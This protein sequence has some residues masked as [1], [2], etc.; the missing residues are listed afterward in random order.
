MSK[1][2][3]NSVE[4]QEVTGQ[5]GAEILRLWAAMVDYSEDQRIGPTILKT[6][7]DS[8]RKLRNTV[9][10]LLGALAGFD[11]A[12]RV[13]AEEAPPLERFILHRLLELDGQA[14]AAYQ[15]HAFTAVIRPLSDF[16]SNDLSSLFFDIRRDVLYCDRP[17]SPRRRACR[18]VMDLVFERLTVWLAPILPFTMEEAWS[19]R[20]PGAGRNSMRVF[21]ST[22]EAWRNPFEADRWARVEWA[23]RV[24]TGALEVER[25]E[26]R[27]GGALEAAPVA[28]INDPEVWAAFDGLDP[29]EVFRTSQATLSRS[30]GPPDAFRLPE[31]AGVAVEPLRAKGAKCAR[32]W[33]ILP[34]VGSDPRY[35]DLSLRDADAVAFWDA[36]HQ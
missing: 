28:Y 26:K 5:S 25:R 23:T 31:I 36:R 10:Y 15:A 14:R 35:P 21:P 22:P 9:R 8:Y 34:E 30:A 12:E 11:D 24:V 19:A 4:P 20:F 13:G 27:I 3:G 16:C 7:I 6:T 17:D 1:S 18:T 2:T 32:S 33:R 29:A